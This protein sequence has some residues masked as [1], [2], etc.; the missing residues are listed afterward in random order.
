MAIFQIFVPWKCFANRSIQNEEGFFQSTV[1]TELHGPTPAG[2]SAYPV[3]V[4]V[5]VHAAVPSAQRTPQFLFRVR[6]DNADLYI[7]QRINGRGID[8]NDQ[9]DTVF[10]KKGRVDRVQG[11]PVYLPVVAADGNHHLP[12]GLRDRGA[13]RNVPMEPLHLHRYPEACYPDLHLSICILF[14][15]QCPFPLP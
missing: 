2:R 7:D 12:I 14:V 6:G 15:D 9:A 1:P 5:S 10:Q 8:R 11:D 13:R 4:F 3:P